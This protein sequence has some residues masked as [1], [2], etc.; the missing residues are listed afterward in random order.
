VTGRPPVTGRRSRR[1]RG[2]APVTLTVALVTLVTACSDGASPAD[3]A[4]APRAGDPAC[5]A[6]LAAAPGTVLGRNRAPLPVAG[7]LA[8]GEPPVVLRC[9]LPRQPPTPQRCL[10]VN[11]ADWI[12]DTTGDPVVFTSYGRDP[13]VEVRVPLAVGRANAP[14]AL[15]GLAPVAAALPATSHTCVG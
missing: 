3:V 10:S 15:V 1:G 8:W 7:T 4:A 9:G 6:A 2:P 11:G 12:V 13:A 14:S 5:A